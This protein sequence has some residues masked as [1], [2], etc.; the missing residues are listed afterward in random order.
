MDI[1]SISFVVIIIGVIVVILQ[2]ILSRQPSSPK[3]IIKGGDKS[4]QAL[5]TKISRPQKNTRTSYRIFSFIHN[6]LQ[7][8]SKRY[9][10][11]HLK[12]YFKLVL[13]TILI[14]LFITLIFKPVYGLY[15]LAVISAGLILDF[16]AQLIWPREW[17]ETRI[18]KIKHQH[19]TQKQLDRELIRIQRSTHTSLRIFFP[20]HERLRLRFSW[21]YKWHLFS[22]ASQVHWGLLI[23]YLLAVGFG[24]F[25]SVIQPG[26]TRAS[27]VNPR[28]INQP[29]AATSEPLFT[30]DS[31]GVIKSDTKMSAKKELRVG[32]TTISTSLVYNENS[33]DVLPEI[34]TLPSTNDRFEIKIPRSHEFQPGK[35]QLKV[36]IR[37][38]IYNQTLTQD[39]TWGV[40]AINP[41]QAVY[42]PKQKSFL[43]MAVLNDTG[44]MV[45]DAKVNL[46]IT[47]PAGI[48]KVLS[49]DNK[50]I[51]ISDECTVHGITN[52]PDYYATY[53]TKDIGK[54]KLNLVAITPNGTR[55]LADEFRVEQNPDF[56]I[57]REGPTRIYPTDIYTMKITVTPRQNISGSVFEAVPINYEI[58]SQ[59]NMRIETLENAKYLIWNA[60]FIQKTPKSFSYQFKTP[61]KSPDFYL[62]GPLMIGKQKPSTTPVSTPTPTVTQI[63]TTTPPN[64]PSPTELQP[65]SQIP[66]VEVN[67]SI[68]PSPIKGK[69]QLDITPPQSLSQTNPT[70]SIS[71]TP[72]IVPSLNLNPPVTVLYTESRQ[73]Q[74]AID[75]TMLTI[76]GTCLQYNEGATSYC[77]QSETVRFAVGS[78]LNGGTATTGATGT[79]AFSAFTKPAA[80]TITV[81]ISGTGSMSHRAAAVTY[82]N[83]VNTT[84][85]VTLYE[86]HLVIGSSENT[87]TTNANISSYDYSASSNNADLFYDVDTSSNLNVD[88][89][90]ASSQELL[91]IKTSNIYRPASA[92]GVTTTSHDLKNVGTI[93]ADSNAIKLDGS[94]TNSGT[95]TAGTSTVTM[96]ASS[97]TESIN[98]S[99][100][101]T[102]T[103]NNLTLGETSG[104]AT[105]NLSSDLDVNGT[106]SITYG[107]LAMG[108]IASINC[109]GN[110]T[111]GAS[112]AYTKSNQ[113]LTF[114][115]ASSITSN[116]QNLGNISVAS[117]ITITQA[118]SSAATM[119]SLTINSTATWSTGGSNLTITTLANSGT[120][121]VSGGETLTIT[122]DTDSGT[123]E[124]YG[125]AGPYTIQNWTYWD[126]KIN[127][128]ST[129]FN[130][131]AAA[132]TVNDA[133]NLAAGTYA[134]GADRNLTVKGNFTIASTGS[135]FTKGSGTSTLI[136]SGAVASATFTGPTTPQDLGAVQIGASP[137]DVY[138][139]ADFAAST[140][141][142]DAG[143]VFYTKGYEVDIGSGGISLTTGSP[144]GTM[145]TTDTGGAG[146]E[147]DGTIVTDAGAFTV[148]SGAVFTKDATAPKSLVKMDGGAAANFTS[149]S[150]DIGD[151][152]TSTASTH[153]D[154]VDALDADTVT[155]DGSTTLHA[156]NLNVT[157]AGN[158]ANSG[159]F[160]AGT[161]TV[162]FNGAV[163]Q[164]ITTAAQAFYGLTLNN[165]GTDGTADD[166]LVISNTLDVNSTFTITNGQLRL[167]TNN[168]NVTCAGAVA[169]GA[170]GSVTHG[171]GTW[172]MDGGATVNLTSNSQDLGNFQTS[173]ASTH[174]DLQDA[175]TINNLTIDASTTLDTVSG[176]NR[177]VSLN[178]LTLNGTFS[179][180]DSTVTVADNWDNSSAGGSYTTS[181]GANTVTF[182]AA[183][184]SATINASTTYYNTG[185]LFRTINLPTSGT[186]TTTLASSI[187]LNN[188]INLG[189][190]TNTITAASSKQIEVWASGTPV[191]NNNANFNTNYLNLLYIST[192]A[193]NVAAGTSFRNIEFRA[194][195][196]NVTFSLAGDV[197]AACTVTI[198]AATDSRTST[199]DLNGH[200]LTSTGCSGVVVGYSTTIRNGIIQN[201]GSAKS[202]VTANTLTINAGAGNN[203]LLTDGTN[204]IDFNVSG[205][206]TNSETAGSVMTNS[207]VTFL[208]N[209]S[210]H[211][212]ITTGSQAFYNL[213]LNNDEV[214]YDQVSI[215]GN[216]DVDNTLTLT[217]GKLKLDTYN[218][219]AYLAGSVSI[220]SAA[221]WT[222]GTGTVTFNGTTAQTYADATATPQNI[223]LVDITKTNGTPSN[224]KIT[225]NS[226]MT[227][228]TMTISANNTLDLNTSSYILNLAY[229][230]TGP[231]P[232]EPPGGRLYP[233][234]R[235][236]AANIFH[237]DKAL[238]G[239][240]EITVL[241]VSG[242]L[243]PGTSTVKY[244]TTSVNSSVN[245]TA[246]TYDSLQLSG[247][248]TYQLN[249]HLTGSNAL[250]GNITIDSGSTLDADST[251]NYG[252]TLAGN[253]TNNGG[254]FSPQNNTVTF[255]GNSKAIN[256]TSATQTFY[257]LTDNKTAGQTLSV[258]GSTTTLSTTNFTETT[259]NFTAP[260]TFNISGN[261]ILT[262]GTF[263][264]GA[265]TNVGG[266]WTKNGGTF[267][268][269]SGIVTFNG[270]ASGKTINPG[271]SSGDFYNLIFN[272]S[273][274]T[275]VWSP[276][277]NTVTVTNDLTMTA[278]TF[279]TS[280]GTASV[281]VNGNVAGTAGV[282]NFTSTNTF[283]QNVATNK[284]F[285][286]TTGSTGWTFYNLT[287]SASA[288][289]P[290]ITTQT[291]GSGDITV[292][293]KMD[294][295]Y[296]TYNTILKGGNR[297]WHLQGTQ[298]FLAEMVNG[299]FTP[300]NSTVSFEATGNINIGTG[301]TFY[302]L[303]TNPASSTPT[304]TLYNPNLSFLAGT[305][306][307]TPT[308]EKNIEDLKVSD[309]VKSYDL[310]SNK[311]VMTKV[312]DTE[313]GQTNQYYIINNKVRTTVDH[314]FV[315]ADKKLKKVQ[316]FKI[317]DQIIV[318]GGLE[319]VNKIQTV[320]DPVAIYDIE[321]ENY[322]LFYAD[323][324]LTHNVY[325]VTVNNDLTMTN[326]GGN[327]TLDFVGTSYATLGV[328]GNISIATNQSLT[329]YNVTLTGNYSNAG[330]L[331]P[332]G[333]TF[334]FDKGS[335]TQTLN[336]GGTGVGKSFSAITHS[337]AGTLQLSTY[338]LDVNGVF[339]NS[340]GTFDANDLNI[341]FAD[342]FLISGGSFSADVSPGATTQTVTF[343]GTNEATISGSTIFN[344][345]TMDTTT[346]GAKTI[347]FTTGTT[348]TITA[349]Q[350]WTLDG[351]SGKV[352][353]LRSTSDTNAWTFDI[354]AGFT[355]G[356]YIDVK[357]SWSAD[358]NYI[359]PGANVTNSGNNAGWVFNHTPTND[360][361]TFTNPYTTNV[362]VA[363]DTTEWTFRTETTDSDGPTNI[364]YIEIR[365]A[366]S[367]DNTLPYDALKYRWTEATDT[368][369]EQ[370]DTQ[371]AGTIT[372]TATDS[373]ASG[374]KWTL[375]FKIKISN[376]FLAKDTNY[377]I[378]L[379]SIDDSSASDDDDYSNKYQVTSLSITLGVD[380]GSVSLSTLTPG[381]PQT[382]KTIATVTTNFPNGYSLSVQDDVSGS[383]SALLHTDTSTRI[384]DYTGTI[385]SPT[386]WTG[387]GLGI[388]VYIATGKNESQWGSGTSET[389]VNNKYAG[390]PETTTSI[391]AKTGSPTSG[392]QTYIGYKIDIPNSQK[393]GTYSGDVTYTATGVLN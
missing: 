8:R 65:L 205:H 209:A 321:V 343:D 269:S 139:A 7:R 86:E 188:S 234:N 380:S 251:N 262:A 156:N 384:A 114:D 90:N 179:A 89:N 100:A 217:D 145:D 23:L 328:T 340:N 54:Y 122:N 22:F 61:D 79:F 338:A 228:D 305:K 303:Q 77:P 106:L 266:S 148:N 275:G 173:T 333:Y 103:F 82:Y 302:N 314:K 243:T 199:L 182:T 69:D 295:V 337:G 42:T 368:F 391:H 138:L 362:A 75:A 213:T 30:V 102:A 346:D 240:T 107:T 58:I 181:T 345:L 219:N 60:K 355:S 32:L 88:V 85:S 96:T 383:N 352:L 47:D 387:T 180:N 192:S 200:N 216:L 263:T 175:L 385:A 227:V 320:N 104:T 40:L 195:T 308:G 110:L 367:T 356:D 256:G 354:S 33:V 392:D 329:T 161:D 5:D 141:T 109:A 150:Q 34:T 94:Y 57:K 68:A 127:G 11:W 348:Q 230:Y 298:N 280:N 52:L 15:A 178:A 120:L 381:S 349:G 92:G 74:M 38:P 51:T 211:Q 359:T 358:T 28:N 116:S 282:I 247:A 332:G 317:G 31:G 357:D 250:T 95:F 1:V 17:Q 372:S 366:N 174:V 81:F 132:L 27:F 153:V 324:Y 170:S 24:F 312:T 214:T 374:N 99:G 149:G 377:N 14:I 373:N 245:V 63:P 115:G 316:D 311:V 9:Y 315:M 307:L 155:I 18:S 220:A 288:A 78:T 142:V 25:L 365:F 196:N 202:T 244:S 206:W 274:G 208:G 185:K 71:P 183:D 272:S 131:P 248:E 334:T 342:D 66:T 165:T 151:F 55:E 341:N 293:G 158:W 91:Y 261:L 281:T 147:Q 296:L 129:T 286:T 361:L 318:F 327:A 160:T 258:S 369:S 226:S 389:D 241:T 301:T 225:L 278:G 370:A 12:S 56:L 221:T 49:T 80:N 260:A 44:A 310:A 325:D 186:T 388:C 238:A 215:S 304:Y 291:G 390:V 83:S 336:S 386:S 20:W 19:L 101:S 284:N 204:T 197:T 289:S 360:A 283:T 239:A 6:Q 13:F 299:T 48:Q 223:G 10:N 50:T 306:V 146:Y 112:G 2:Q 137:G 309:L 268:N 267:T 73:W 119:D 72:A 379:Y 376:S 218:P 157:V 253:W 166:D 351:A 16:F 335:S 177:A 133:F 98:S 84:L 264:A 121:K 236:Q 378:E 190:S 152:Q 117:G 353:T 159:T 237:F 246:T 87:T 235:A 330:T 323:N 21:Y 207:T 344:N 375:D 26:A 59:P 162:T 224:N 198:R 29:L 319:T 64:T 105:W 277:T 255:T 126:L 364:N 273:G 276:L 322:H 125:T 43:G 41:D 36:T 265:N 35:Y 144:G 393:T 297:T 254:T 189:S 46:T 140:L 97:G 154:L 259:G 113:T 193:T 194:A 167:D 242:T 222:K 231:A 201:T 130:Q 108:D 134:Q 252:I 93:T 37:S 313:K 45:C 39:F 164:T 123:V 111:I 371:G 326:G 70:V 279:D 203:K 3:K 290:T 163:Q 169:I 229:V 287:F 257:A 212:I 339:T 135:T 4:P 347:K 270:S 331:T 171:S 62:T 124:Y 191:I 168:P 249:G 53:Q 172:I 363:D 184:G 233:I 382:N 294:I 118:A 176:S 350:T 136:L 76:S 292:K 210:A 128:A 285:G 232:S 143:D 271:A 67:P 300:D 187:S